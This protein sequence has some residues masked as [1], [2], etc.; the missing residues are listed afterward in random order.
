MT[1]LGEGKDGQGSLTGGLHG[2]E[3]HC[4]CSSIAMLMIKYVPLKT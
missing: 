2:E 1:H 3:P 4:I